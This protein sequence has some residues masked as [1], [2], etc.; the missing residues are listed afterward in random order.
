MKR[1]VVFVLLPFLCLA[2]GMTVQQFNDLKEDIINELSAVSQSYSQIVYDMNMTYELG[3]S[4]YQSIL[5]TAARYPNSEIYQGMSA[6]A[7]QMMVYFTDFQS[8]RND[9]Q[10][11]IM[12]VGNAINMVNQLTAPSNSV[13]DL[14]PVIAAIH[15]NTYYVVSSVNSGVHD[16]TNSVALNIS[17]TLSRADVAI[18]NLQVIVEILQNADLSGGGSSGGSTDVSTIEGLLDDIIDYLSSL[19]D[20]VNVI[21]SDVGSIASFVQ[22]CLDPD[23]P[24][25][26][27]LNL[28]HSRLD[29]PDVSLSADLALIWQYCLEEISNIVYRADGYSLQSHIYPVVSDSSVHLS[30]EG[31][32][33][34]QNLAMNQ[35][36]YLCSVAMLNELKGLNS[37]N[38]L[39]W[40]TNYLG[41]VQS[42]YYSL[43]NFLPPKSGNYYSSN[44][45]FTSYTNFLRVASSGA[46]PVWQFQSY[47]NQ[48]SNWFA[49]VEMQLMTLNGLFPL[50]HEGLDEF[51]DATSDEENND[52]WV[53]Y[54]TNNLVAVAESFAGV[55]N[56]VRAVLSEYTDLIQNIW[57]DN[58]ESLSEIT[59]MPSIDFGGIQ[60][61]HIHLAYS[62]IE[63]V[64]DAI[65]LV[66]QCLYW[67]FGVMFAFSAFRW[68]LRVLGQVVLGLQKLLGLVLS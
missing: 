10:S 37:T 41:Q 26:K 66:C 58:L 33:G 42:R 6:G 8:I 47:S 59:I 44:S 24:F 27:Y 40:I 63:P 29:S 32:I 21:S 54:S 23:N 3:L 65:R 1:F 52:R 48:Q 64:G 17:H 51:E 30:N 22:W 61:N 28:A 55:S 45:G 39:A 25:Q 16:I 56:T 62:D 49:R 38:N 46:N 67:F 15:S 13:V 50:R 11:N 68:L 57:P 36:Q 4:Q 53:R 43:F 7:E 31:L 20:S 2:D 35:R 34:L 60:M 19:L 5:E 14:S 18:S 9:L 12:S